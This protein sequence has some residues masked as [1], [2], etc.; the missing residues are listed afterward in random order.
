MAGGI[1]GV[2]VS[3]LTPLPGSAMHEQM[4]REGRLLHEDWAWFNG[5]IYPS[6]S[7]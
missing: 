7:N 6:R 2:T 5:K 1:E 3:L 4:K